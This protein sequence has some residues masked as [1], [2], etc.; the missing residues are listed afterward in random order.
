MADNRKLGK[1]LEALINEKVRGVKL[2]PEVR[3]YIDLEFKYFSKK[4]KLQEM[5]EKLKKTTELIFLASVRGKEVDESELRTL[6]REIKAAKEELE[7]VRQGL[8]LIKRNLHS[9]GIL[10]ILSRDEKLVIE[11]LEKTLP[12]AERDTSILL[13]E[14]EIPVA[15]EKDGDDEVLEVMLE[16][17]KRKDKMGVD[18]DIGEMKEKMV[19]ELEDLI[20]PQL[21]E[22]FDKIESALQNLKE[23]VSV[24]EE[25]GELELEE[26]EPIVIEELEGEEVGEEEVNLEA[27]KEEIHP[28]AVSRRVAQEVGFPETLGEV[29][30]SEEEILELER[31][32][33]K[34]LEEMS[35]SEALQLALNMIKEERLKDAEKALVR[36]VKSD[37]MFYLAWYHLGGVYYLQGDMARAKS[38]F[39]KANAIKPGVPRVMIR[40]ADVY[41]K[42]QMRREALVLLKEV[43]RRNPKDYKALTVAAEV[44]LYKGMYPTAK[45]YLKTALRINPK[46][47]RA[48][49]NLAILQRMESENNA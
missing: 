40:L 33:E 6:E 13:K 5:E 14:E 17:I 11:D 34:P 7:A 46:Y 44:F 43:L 4:K 16:G 35:R 31:V 48:I 28:E 45:K 10:E 19:L 8:L 18:V 25:N 20:K 12:A 3:D 26:F 1:G 29:E 41:N 22:A 30:E 9:S 38:A 23:G 37:P 2:T 24:E 15:T 21:L 36:L 42:M 27:L 47:E 49:K 32:P 39:Q